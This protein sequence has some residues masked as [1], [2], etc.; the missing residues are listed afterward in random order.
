M[1][2]KQYLTIIAGIFVSALLFVPIMEA[3]DSNDYNL[4]STDTETG[5][6]R[7]KPNSSFKTSGDCYENIVEV[8]NLGFHGAQV[9]QLKE[10]DTFRIVVVGS[11]YVSAIQVPVDDMFSTIL[12]N[13][14]NAD[15]YR[16]YSYEVIPI[17]IG[18]QSRMLLDIFYYLKY[19]ASLKPDLIINIESDQEL[20]DEHDINTSVLDERGNVI[21]VTPK[22][23]ESS[24][25]ALARS[26]SRHSKLLVN[27][28]NRVL[29]FKSNLNSY[30]SEPF[31]TSVQTTVPVENSATEAESALAE[32]ELWQKKEKMLNIF[33]EQ[34]YKDGAKF[35]YASWTGPWTKTSIALEFPKH[36][37]EIAEKN[38]FPYVD[39][40]PAFRAKEIGSGKSGTY[41]C[42]IHW[43]AD[44]NEYV[45]DALFSYLTSNKD[46]FM[47]KPI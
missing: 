12:E 35:V 2:L 45:A 30:L 25:V 10:K 44:G 14:L 13:R 3:V 46:L 5:L 26:I 21:A 42:D 28:Y 4:L 32:K 37:A 20:I 47:R 7:Y 18:G 24:G 27:L 22:G 17:A 23:D 31:A 16:K 6:Y 33:A 8:N 43:N 40:T 36:G 38:N 15:S 34:V 41:L 1:D 39:I 19:G 29:V 11:S 9:S